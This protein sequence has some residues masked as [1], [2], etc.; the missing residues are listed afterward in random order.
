M[1]WV[2][3]NSLADALE[4]RQVAQAKTTARR[5]VKIIPLLAKIKAIP[6]RF[7]RFNMYY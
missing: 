3:F 7:R 4:P 2:L 6:I 1:G 5:K